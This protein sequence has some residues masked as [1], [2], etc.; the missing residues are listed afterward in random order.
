MALTFIH[1]HKKSEGGEHCSPWQSKNKYILLQNIEAEYNKL[2]IFKSDL[3]HGM[4]YNS[5]KFNDTFRKNQVIF[6][7]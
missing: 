7:K 6:I 2:V 1:K 3:Y 4:A 5:D